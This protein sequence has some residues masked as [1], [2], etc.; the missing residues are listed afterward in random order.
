M[1]VLGSGLSHPQHDPPNVPSPTDQRRFT[2]EGIVASCI[3][4]LDEFLGNQPSD[5]AQDREPRYQQAQRC[6]AGNTPF[7]NMREVLDLLRQGS[8]Q[9]GAELRASVPAS[10]EANDS[11]PSCDKSYNP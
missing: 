7:P 10:Y 3:T 2:P 1:A 4:S 9:E 6:P 11:Q 8:F 5:H